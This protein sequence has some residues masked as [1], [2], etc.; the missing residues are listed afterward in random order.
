MTMTMNDLRHC[1]QER[2]HFW[3]LGLK[4]LPANTPGLLQQPSLV[5]SE[6]SFTALLTGKGST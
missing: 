3:T 2:L 6:T 1:P 5:V 4:G